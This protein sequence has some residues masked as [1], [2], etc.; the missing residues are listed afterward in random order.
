MK[1][2]FQKNGDIGLATE[3]P[4]T[5]AMGKRS[6]A[7]KNCGHPLT[8]LPRLQ[9]SGCAG[10]MDGCSLSQVPFPSSSRCLSFR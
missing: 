8:L 5:G 10:N 6:K 3:K 7:E 1:Y 4:S 2:V 9:I